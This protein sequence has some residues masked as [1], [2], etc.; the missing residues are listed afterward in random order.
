MADNTKSGQS[1]GYHSNRWYKNHPAV[2]RPVPIP[3]LTPPPKNTPVPIRVFRLLGFGLILTGVGLMF[4]NFLLGVVVVYVGVVTLLWE[5]K[6]DPLFSRPDG[7]REILMGLILVATLVFTAE[8]V[9]TPAPLEFYS[10]AMRKANRSSTDV[11]EGILWDEHFTELR[12]AIT[13]PTGDDYDDFDVA[14]QP[15]KWNY[16]AAIVNSTSGCDLIPIGGANVL[17]AGRNKASGTDSITM[18]RVGNSFEAHDTLG[19]TYN[20]LAVE[21]GYRLR[22]SAFPA[23]Y[24]IRVV[25]ALVA[26]PSRFMPSERPAPGM[27]S[28]QYDEV[29]G[30]T[31]DFDILEARPSPSVVSLS[32]TYKRKLKTYSIIRPIRVPVKDG[33]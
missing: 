25:F 1:P 33:D 12:V 5:L 17:L 23:H 15:D 30:A 11:V 20:P 24:T 22:C 19:N 14:I 29:A 6:T 27:W 10:F 31:S 32:G 21:S 16:K 9:W 3:R 28:A 13:N 18:S 8:I 7:I 2:V 26:P 4:G